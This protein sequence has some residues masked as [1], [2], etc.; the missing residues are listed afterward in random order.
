LYNNLF[1]LMVSCPS[2]VAINNFNG[3]GILLES[4]M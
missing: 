4:S 3:S 2:L 1:D